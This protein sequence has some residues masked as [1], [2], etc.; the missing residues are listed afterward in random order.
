M[1]FEVTKRSLDLIYLY[2]F[3]HV[4]IAHLAPPFLAQFPV[5]YLCLLKLLA[6]LATPP[7]MPRERPEVKSRC[8]TIQFCF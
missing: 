4:Y 2:L 3:V 6:A 7:P 8:L 1:P 5:L